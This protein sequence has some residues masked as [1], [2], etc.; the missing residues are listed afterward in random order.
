MCL[1]GVNFPRL[2]D[3]STAEAEVGCRV[4]SLNKNATKKPANTTGIATALGGS[5]RK[6]TEATAGAVGSGF[7]VLVC[8][9]GC[10]NNNKGK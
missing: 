3:A 10:K 5:I 7:C 6:S 1:G 9:C 4:R 2:E 8:V